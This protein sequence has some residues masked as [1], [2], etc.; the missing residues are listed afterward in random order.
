MFTV[1]QAKRHLKLPYGEKKLIED[2]LPT[3]PECRTM[4]MRSARRMLRFPASA[5]F[6]LT[7]IKSPALVFQPVKPAS[8]SFSQSVLK[9]SAASISKL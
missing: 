4:C 9:Y 5:Y 8:K 3:V 1:V 7:L 6:K 2:L